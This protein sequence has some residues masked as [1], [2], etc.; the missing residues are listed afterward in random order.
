M[1]KKMK[2]TVEIE[3]TK[4]QKVSVGIVLLLCVLVVF[5]I[6][7]CRFFYIA[8]THKV[9]RHNLTTETRQLYTSKENLQ[10]KRGTIYDANGNP[11]AQATT[12]YSL[13]VVLSHKAKEGNKIFYLPQSK[14]KEAAKVISR[15]IDL[16]YKRVYKLLNPKNKNIYQVEFG[17]AGKNLTQKTKKKIE[18]AGL[19]G[20]SFDAQ[21]SRLYP[22]GIFAS[23]MIG[24]TTTID[25]TITGAMGIEKIF[26]KE[27]SG[28]NGVKFSNSV[29]DKQ[30]KNKS[31]VAQDGSDVY[32]TLDTQLQTS[33]E[34]LMT[35][36][37]KKYQPKQ[38]VVILMEAKTGKIVA[39]SQ[40]PSFNAQTKVGL[41]EMW[42]N[43]I[44]NDTYEP[45]SVMKIF[46]TAAA[47]NSGNYNGNA[48]YN[49]GTLQIGN[50]RVYDW[51]RVGWGAITYDQAFIR[52]SNVGM[53]MLEKAMGKSLWLKYIKKFGF[54]KQTD[55]K[56]GTQSSGSIAYKYGFDQAST[57]YGQGINVT[58]IQIM[59]ALTAIS[60]NGVE[61]EPYMLEKMVNPNTKKV[62]QIGKKTIYGRPITKTT[63]KEVRN[64]MAQ[65]VTD[66]NGTGQ[67][68]ASEDFQVG[69]KTGTAQIPASSGTGYLSGDLNYVF[70][71]AGMAPIDNPR[72][73]LY[74]AMKQPQT[75]A[76]KGATNML[77]S[78]FN[79][80][81]SQAIGKT[82]TINQEATVAVKDVRGLNT[83]QAQKALTT[84]GLTVSVV[85]QGRHIVSQSVAAETKLIKNGRVILVTN[86]PKTMPDLK[87]WSR[88]DVATL[89]KILK[90]KV[91]YYGSGYVNEQNISEGTE[92]NSKDELIVNL[93]ND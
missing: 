56:M 43:L 66:K 74:V 78:I 30:A 25:E 57:S 4:T 85:G 45:G 47:I 68:Y 72:Y 15:Y 41:S 18:A 9:N 87:G 3:Q 91:T 65:V 59:R 36:A 48:Y 17:N 51:N 35:K 81:M 52:S 73:V 11:I 38:M 76:G 29:N 39:V 46:T 37:Q 49:S 24:Y 28:T 75:F 23:H 2:R 84:Q 60:N 93:N 70:S 21:Q 10:A 58:P 88:K 54:L 12:T 5:L 33:L 27:L 67:A 8:T 64:L 79:P 6:F 92:I 19:T 31:K 80:L 7:I 69:V 53:A 83:S 13:Y 82:K 55:F 22:N 26:D 1:N 44:L 90:L 42:R 63:A 62:T 40:R 16:P 32:T 14:K 89:A 61:L 77:A 34:N 50:S 71:V 86:G 20:I